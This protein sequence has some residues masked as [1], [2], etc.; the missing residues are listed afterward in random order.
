MIRDSSPLS[1]AFVPFC[2]KPKFIWLFKDV[3]QPTS[4]TDSTGIPARP[5]EDAAVRCPACRSEAEVPL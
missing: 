1:L 3:L 4:D 2:K 5:V